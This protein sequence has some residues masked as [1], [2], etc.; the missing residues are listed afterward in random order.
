MSTD[1]T[2]SPG[3]TRTTIEVTSKRSREPLQPPADSVSSEDSGS[4]PHS[5][6]IDED[7]QHQSDHP[8]LQKL[9]Q[10]STAL[11]RTY[12]VFGCTLMYTEYAILKSVFVSRVGHPRLGVTEWIPERS[13]RPDVFRE[14]VMKHLSNTDNPEFVPITAD[15]DADAI[16]TR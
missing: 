1:P 9:R 4:E 8:G 14:T 15:F 10:Q 2:T 13:Y 12:S 6:P 3:T 5:E 7:A 16:L 11:R